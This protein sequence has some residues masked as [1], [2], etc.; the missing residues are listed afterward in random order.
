MQFFEQACLYRQRTDECFLY[1]RHDYNIETLTLDIP[2]P[3]QI[4][5]APASAE[6]Y[7][8]M[9]GKVHIIPRIHAIFKP[10][11]CIEN[12][13]GNSCKERVWE[14]MEL[15]Y[16][17][18]HCDLS[19]N[20]QTS[21]II[22]TMCKDYGHRLDE[23]IQYH[24]KL[25]FSGIVLFNNDENHVNGLNEPMEHCNTNRSMK[26]IVQQY[27]GRVFM[28]N[29]PYGPFMSQYWYNQHYDVIQRV[30][31]QMSLAEFKHQCKYIALIDADEFIYFPQQTEMSIESFLADYDVT[32][33]IKS[34]ILTNQNDNDR[35][36]NNV[37]SLARFVGEEKYTK[38]LLRTRLAQDNE[39]LFDGHS[40]PSDEIF[41][42]KV[43]CHY[44][45]WMNTRYVYRV[46][47]EEIDCLMNFISHDRMIQE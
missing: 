26:D 14:Q 25:G 40:H 29:F 23:W 30:T 8:Q 16:P 43:I 28:V 34:H 18:E 27:P 24:L 2:N 3:Y 6:F 17:L 35:I 7:I 5:Y 42:K 37:L 19:L 44:H 41:D 4:I 15:Y 36:D 21:A 20:S 32:L 13:P 11:C 31:Q 38:I 45:C 47:M 46:E 39:F 33:R 12:T 1:G 10:C 22:A 9:V